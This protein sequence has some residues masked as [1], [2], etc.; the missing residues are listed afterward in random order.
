ML[1]GRLVCG[2]DESSEPG[3]LHAPATSATAASGAASTTPRRDNRP[4]LNP[5]IYG[6]SLRH[7]P[8]ERVARRG[9]FHGVPSRPQCGT[10]GVGKA[11]V[12]ARRNTVSISRPFAKLI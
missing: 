5:G 3:A 12:G 11:V 6:S 1:T 4:A 8:R 2:V 10:V 7:R 9:G